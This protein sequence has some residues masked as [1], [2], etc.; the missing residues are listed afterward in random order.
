MNKAILS[1]MLVLSMATMAFAVKPSCV[2]NIDDE[3]ACFGF[4][5][6]VA[7]WEYDSGWAPEG[8][9]MGTIVSGTNEN[10]N[11]DVD[12]SGATGIVVKA[13]ST[14]HYGING[15]SGNVVQSSPALSHLTF[16]RNEN[17]QVPEFSTLAATGAFVLAGGVFMLLRRRH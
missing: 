9:D 12:G 5:S 4:D 14:V 8:D 16:C 10:A 3:C 11:W 15:T 6:G 1:I 7:K 17:Y 13:G 2:G